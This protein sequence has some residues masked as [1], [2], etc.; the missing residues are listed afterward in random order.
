MAYAKACP[1]DGYRRLTWMMVD[2]DIVYLTPSTV[3]RILDR[4]DLLYRWK[5]PEL[6][7]GRKVISPSNLL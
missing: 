7:Y 6:G 2:E 5:R 1:R 4:Y 3:Y